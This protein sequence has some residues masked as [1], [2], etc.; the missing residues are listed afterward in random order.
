M[1]AGVLA[2]TL[3]MTV[4][5][6]AVVVAAERE[7]IRVA[8]AVEAAVVAEVVAVAGAAARPVVPVQLSPFP[9]SLSF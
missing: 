8:G 1:A 2:P 6:E 7:R 5:A 4:V 3:P 9:K